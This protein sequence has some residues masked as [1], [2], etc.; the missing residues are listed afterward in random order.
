MNDILF[1]YSIYV[2]R[3]DSDCWTYG[4]RL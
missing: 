3:C 4:P 2:S 1:L